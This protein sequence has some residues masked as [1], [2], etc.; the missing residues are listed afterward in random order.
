VLRQLLRQIEERRLP[1]GQADPVR[2]V[3]VDGRQSCQFRVPVLPDP[4]EDLLQH[5]SIA[6]SCPLWLVSRWGRTFG[7]DQAASIARACALRPPLT[8][9]PNRIRID[10]AGLAAALAEQGFESQV[11]P[12]GQAVV[13]RQGGGLFDSEAFRN[14]LFQ[15]QDRTSMEVVRQLALVPGQA[16]IDLCAGLGTKTTQMAELMSNEGV[17]LASD[18]D[19]GKLGIIREGCE[20]LGHGIIRTV[21]AEGVA[22]EAAGLSRLDWVLIDAPC[23][24]TGV[25]ARRPEARY[26]IS[27]Q[28]LQSL[29][30]LQ[31][32]LLEKGAR[33]ARPETRLLYSTCSIEPEENEQVVT[34][35]CRAKPGWRLSKSRLTLP[36]QGQDWP[37]WRD[38]GF[39]A[40]LHR[41]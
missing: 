12:D 40:E 37:D 9:R 23:S 1:S 38:G 13:V 11:T 10:A 7:R 24:N 26:R 34:A 30:R 32:E 18:K 36:G 16:V 22:G 3:M 33:L 14:G 19:Q 25:L 20:R 8:L 5:L 41:S 28:S 6:N 21:L 4:V 17:I 15:P 39:W 31:G 2:S 29:C 27:R 35:F